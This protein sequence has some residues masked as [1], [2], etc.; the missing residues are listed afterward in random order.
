MLTKYQQ[1]SAYNL[2]YVGSSAR[3]FFYKC[4][5]NLCNY[6]YII[7]L[8]FTPTTTPFNQLQGPF[9]VAAWN[10]TK[11]KV[12]EKTFT[13]WKCLSGFQV[14]CSSFSRVL[15][16]HGFFFRYPRNA[17]RN[18]PAL[19]LPSPTHSSS[20]PFTHPAQFPSTLV[21]AVST[22]APWIEPSKWRN[23]L[24]TPFHK[25][26][27]EISALTRE[28]RT[29]WRMGGGRELMACAPWIKCPCAAGEKARARLSCSHCTRR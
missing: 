15:H 17:P 24:D 10:N 20:F 26:T 28:T 7:V 5:F 4:I 27:S 16:G 23:V 29:R 1:I 9:R 14:L 8:I 3:R 2:N 21:Y 19:C 11:I 6:L 18:V 13:P 22:A 12:A 25:E